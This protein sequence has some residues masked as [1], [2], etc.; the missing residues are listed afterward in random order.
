MSGR[1][2]SC[3]TRKGGARNCCDQA[4]TLIDP[5]GNGCS[6]DLSLTRPKS[7]HLE[8]GGPGFT[9]TTKRNS[10]LLAFASISQQPG[11]RKIDSR[12]LDRS[13][14][15]RINR[16]VVPKW[17]SFPIY[18]SASHTKR[19]VGGLVP[20]HFLTGYMAPFRVKLIGSTKHKVP[21][22]KWL[23]GLHGSCS[24]STMCP[25]SRF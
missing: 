11:G 25:R 12:R 8:V 13:A 4:V 20:Q 9:N 5:R 17:R 23:S 22:P 19:R 10:A 2:F 6:F 1:P 3:I 18:S 16:D 24:R 7:F 15:P 21:A 14:R